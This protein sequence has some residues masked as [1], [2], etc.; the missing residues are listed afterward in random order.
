MYS[1]SSEGAFK[2][3]KQEISLLAARS[4]DKEGKPLFD[5]LVF[6]EAELILFRRYFLKA[7]TEVLDMLPD[8]L[9]AVN[10]DWRFDDAAS[11]DDTNFVFY[12]KLQTQPIH[13]FKKMD[14]EIQE[15]ITNC[16]CYNWLQTKL[17]DLSVVY[18]QNMDA[19][20]NNIKKTI[21][22][23]QIGG[24]DIKRYPSFP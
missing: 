23:I 24:R 4:T 14:T 18:Y 2:Y 11:D 13:L 21:A 7:Q 8:R 12:L 22:R 9:L 6:D 20:R 19:L 3:V 1:Y 10:D 17:P 5:K 15:Y 16:I